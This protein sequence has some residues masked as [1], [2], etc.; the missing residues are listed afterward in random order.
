MEN[1]WIG[2]LAN[3]FKEAGET[4]KVHEDIHRYHNGREVPQRNWISPKLLTAILK[5]FAVDIVNSSFEE[6]QLMINE[7]NYQWNELGTNLKKTKILRNNQVETQDTPIILDDN[8]LS[9]VGKY[10]SIYLGQITHNS[11]SL[12]SE[13]K[14]N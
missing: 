11:D 13:T 3:L 1:P 4:I 7:W 10:I 5:R 9:I 14:R 6:L 8:S 12:I 2:T